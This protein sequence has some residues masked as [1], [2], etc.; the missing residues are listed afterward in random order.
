M[1]AK[2]LVSPLPVAILCAVLCS[3]GIYFGI[4]RILGVP[5]E[6]RGLLT[7]LRRS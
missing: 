2:D 5:E 4:L 6:D 7:A 3:V 1:A